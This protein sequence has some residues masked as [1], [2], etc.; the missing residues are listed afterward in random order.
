MCVKWCLSQLGKSL[1]GISLCLR[2][3]LCVCVCEW[4]TGILFKTGYRYIGEFEEETVGELE[5]FYAK[6]GTNCF[7]VSL[8]YVGVLIASIGCCFV[9][10]LRQRRYGHQSNDDDDD[11][12]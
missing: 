3:C 7:M 6:A 1:S 11:E 2:S 9:G 8:A 4:W 10:N 12:K 5:E